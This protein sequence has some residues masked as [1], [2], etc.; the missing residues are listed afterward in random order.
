MAITVRKGFRNFLLALAMVT[1]SAILNCAHATDL[2]LESF[3]PP[4]SQLPDFANE[5]KS[6]QNWGQTFSYDSVNPTYEVDKIVLVLYRTSDALPQTLTVSLRST[7]NGAVIAQGSLA[8]ASLPTSEA[9]TT[10]ELNT[11][12][13]LNDNVAYYIR[14][15]SSTADGKI[16]LGIDETNSYPDGDATDKDG[17]PLTGRDLAF[18]II[19]FLEP[20]MDVLGLGISIPDN[21]ATPST[22]DD[23]DFGQHDINTGTNAN[24]FTIANSGTDALNLSGTP[25][26]LI[27]GT[28]AADFILTTDA[29]TTIAA[30]GGT[31]TFTVTFD[32]SA[33]GLRTAT[34]SIANDDDDE[35]PYNFSIQGTGS[36]TPEMTIAKSA[37]VSAVNNAGDPI[38]YTITLTNTGPIAI[39]NI[40]VTDPLLSG[41]SC[42]PGSG[43]N[44]DTMAPAAV[45]TC[46]GTYNATQVDFDTNGGGDGDI[47]NTATVTGDGDGGFGTI[48]ESDS[49]AVTLNIN[50]SLSVNKTA[51][52][53]TDVI[54]GQIITYTYVVGNNG[55]QT[56][57]D[58]QLSENHNGSGPPP[59]P[60]NETLTQDNLPLGDSTD[61]STNGIWDS[62]APGDEVTFTATYVVTQQDVDTLQ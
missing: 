25:R 36:A 55:N 27:S 19:D 5:V 26:V 47:D 44:P 17:L 61:I 52:D 1:L 40:I 51:D 28:H 7:W 2:I 58:L 60:S 46:S 57:T 9:W 56:I 20:E 34:I 16:Y 18:R 3:E 59:V 23:T 41:L 35:N 37:D 53:T 15:D 10:I 48:N 11:P 31:T 49:T 43:A 29:N 22:L 62:I 6:D 42:A 32:P 54:A 38:F 30:G 8:S 21:D 45:A 33:I 50:A 4:F 39:N 12:A 13:T 24:T 14:V